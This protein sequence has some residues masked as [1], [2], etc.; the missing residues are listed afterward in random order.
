[1]KINPSISFAINVLLMLSTGIAT[2]AVSFS[3]LMSDAAAKHV[4]GWFAIAA[5]VISTINT[6]LH[7]Y[8]AP[9]A[10]PL[11][12]DAPDAPVVP[13][14]N[15]SRIGLFLIAGA[16]LGLVFAML[17]PASAAPVVLHHE[18]RIVKHAK[19]VASVPHVRFVP[20]RQKL[21]L[22]LNL[23][24]QQLQAVSLTDLQTAEADAT[25]Q[26]DTVAAACYAQIITLVS[27]QQ[28]ALAAQANLP[29]VHVVTSFQQ[30]R[31]FALALRPGSALSTACAPLANEV[32]MDVLNLVAGVT[33]GSLSL[34][35]FGL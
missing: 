3:G 30:A 33:A 15:V 34:S 14:A 18:H 35:S 11:V 31:D 23:L 8:S 22:N 9:S 28:K 29:D 12:P 21:S 13:P 7:G 19:R 20:Q 25:A 5:F 27:N 32:K 2:G 24:L 6:A 16:A 26:K 1:M 4:V 10:G 17:Q